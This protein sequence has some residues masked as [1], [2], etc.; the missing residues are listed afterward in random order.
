MEDILKSD[1]LDFQELLERLETMPLSIESAR[2]VFEVIE[3]YLPIGEAEDSGNLFS[4]EFSIADEVSTQLKILRGLRR[5][6][7]SSSGVPM[8]NADPIEVKNMLMASMSMI[9]TLVA[10]QD[11]IINHDR[12]QAIERAFIGVIGQLEPEGRDKFEILLKEGLE[13]IR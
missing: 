13:K 10:L 4:A 7:V 3:R 6:L 11:D 1:T 12:L 9:K 2:Q 5:S 8:T